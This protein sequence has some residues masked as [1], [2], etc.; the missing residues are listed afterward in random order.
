MLLA[1]CTAVEKNLETLVRYYNKL[2]L[3]KILD[4]CN[5]ISEPKIHLIA[6]RL[7]QIQLDETTKLKE[8]YYGYL[9]FLN[10]VP[11]ITFIAFVVLVYEFIRRYII[12]HF[13]SKKKMI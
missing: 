10:Y 4:R 8:L 6:D 13:R 1:N 3:Y 7:H 9:Q 12:D 2:Q 5:K 11:F